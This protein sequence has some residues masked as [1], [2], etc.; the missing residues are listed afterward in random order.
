MKPPSAK[1]VRSL[2][3]VTVSVFLGSF[4][5]FLAL[6]GR[7]VLDPNWWWSPGSLV[8]GAFWYCI[9]G[10]CLIPFPFALAAIV[11]PLIRAKVE[12][13]NAEAMGRAIKVILWII[14]IL[15]VGL[16]FLFLLFILSIT[17]SGGFYKL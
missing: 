6:H 3:F 11:A 8:T 2:W 13:D 14:G 5:V 17:S 4:V 15:I 7:N 10:W 1:T 12:P 16:A 9:S